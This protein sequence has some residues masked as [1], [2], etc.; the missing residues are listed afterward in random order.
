PLDKAASR[1][2]M[3]NPEAIDFFVRFAEESIDHQWRRL[4]SGQVLALQLQFCLD[5][6]FCGCG[7]MG[8][9]PD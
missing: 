9:S 5:M 4:E 7:L 1:D 6:G 8:P 3:M 2:A